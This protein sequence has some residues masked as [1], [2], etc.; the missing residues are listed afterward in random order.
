MSTQAHDRRAA[1][2]WLTAG[3]KHARGPAEAI[4]GW[5]IPRSLLDPPML[6]FAPP[7]PLASHAPSK[8][9]HLDLVDPLRGR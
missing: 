9:R 5:P 8:L 1:I 7:R 4:G 6:G 2:G 3:R